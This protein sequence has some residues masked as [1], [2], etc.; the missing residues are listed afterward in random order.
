MNSE[1]LLI[2]LAD[3]EIPVTESS[4]TPALGWIFLALV[5]LSLGIYFFLHKRAKKNALTQPQG[6]A[7]TKLEQLEK[8]WQM[9]KTPTRQIA[10]QLST[11][12]RLGLGLPQL[13][14]TPPPFIQQNKENWKNTITLLQRLRYAS[15]ETE[16]LNYETFSLARSWLIQYSKV[17]S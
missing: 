9:G 11:V 10:Y 6:I 13:T 17:T 14:E 4:S 5:T 12:L 3:I 7:L 15:H 1:Q 2:Q 8:Q 16:A